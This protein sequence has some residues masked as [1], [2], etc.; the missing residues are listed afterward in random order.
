MLKIGLRAALV[1]VLS[2]FAAAGTK[3]SAQSLVPVKILRSIAAHFKGR[4]MEA[5]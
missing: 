3:A 4:A 1:L 2:F 5:G